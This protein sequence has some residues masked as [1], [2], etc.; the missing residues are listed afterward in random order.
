[1]RC[2]RIPGWLPAPAAD[3][4]SSFPASLFRPLPR[5]AARLIPAGPEQC[6]WRPDPLRGR[7]FHVKQPAKGRPVRR[8]RSRLAAARP[9]HTG[10][11][12]TP[13]LECRL[14][15][16]GTSAAA[17]S[18][19]QAAGRMDRPGGTGAAGVSGG[20]AF[21]SGPVTGSR[22]EN[23]LPQRTR[24][25]ARTPERPDDAPD[26]RPGPDRPC[27]GIPVCP[28][29]TLPV[30]PVP[31]LAGRRVSGRACPFRKVP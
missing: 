18:R 5:P 11:G 31:A 6:G 13:R 19:R 27:P 17:G 3:R 15:A 14:P 8:A 24:A 4:A 7:L 1:M 23:A 22:E 2:G 30:P 20:W 16:R 9:E 10:N 12:R 25:P 29:R 21:S 28:F 26:S